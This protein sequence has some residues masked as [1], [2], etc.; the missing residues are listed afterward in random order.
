MVA[1]SNSLDWVKLVDLPH[2]V[3]KGQH[4]NLPFLIIKILA[5]PTHEETFDLDCPLYLV[6]ALHHYL[7]YVAVFYVPGFVSFLLWTLQ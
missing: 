3:T 4:L 7:E 6:W 2:L 1:F 5:L